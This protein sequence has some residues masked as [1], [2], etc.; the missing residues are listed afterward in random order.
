MKPRS[1][2]DAQGSK[3]RHSSF[4]PRLTP[5]VTVALVTVAPLL[6]GLANAQQHEPESCF[7]PA[8]SSS[9]TVPDDWRVVA[10]ASTGLAFLLPRGHMLAPSEGIWYVH[11]TMDGEPLVPDVSIRLHANQTAEEVARRLF[12]VGAKLDP[13]MLGPAA[14]GFR[15]VVPGRTSAEGYLAIGGE[16]IFSITRYE[17]FD[18]S[19][20]DQV[21]C[22]F[23]LIELVSGRDGL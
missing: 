13:V 22:S 14:H 21:A 19:D 15:V 9:L 6:F 2:S 12:A 16:G 4:M 17:E 3:E 5:I 18:W 8:S 1:H 7:A 20:F 11:G 10:D 23:H